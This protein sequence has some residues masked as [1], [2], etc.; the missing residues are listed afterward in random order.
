M[1]L[2]KLFPVGIKNIIK[3]GKRPSIFSWFS[4]KIRHHAEFS[5]FV[6][7]W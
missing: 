1:L 5:L 3:I 7:N 2:D 6:K 4:E